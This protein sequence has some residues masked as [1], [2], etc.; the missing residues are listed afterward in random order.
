MGRASS[1]GVASSRARERCTRWHFVRLMFAF[2]CTLASTQTDGHASRIHLLIAWQVRDGEDLSSRNA[3][4]RTLHARLVSSPRARPSDMQHVRPACC[5]A[6]RVHRRIRSTNFSWWRDEFSRTDRRGVLGPTR[7]Q[8]ER[9]RYDLLS[10]RSVSN[11]ARRRETGYEPLPRPPSKKSPGG[12]HD[13]S[14]SRTN[15]KA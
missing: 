11:E 7:T 10:S 3:P 15:P 14:G 1:V 4:G 8:V 6:L 2:A 9:Y 13:G 5:D 12:K